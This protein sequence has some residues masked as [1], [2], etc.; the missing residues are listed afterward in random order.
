PTGGV[1]RHAPSILK[2][3]CGIG[4]P[5][6]QGESAKVRKRRFSPIAPCPRECPLTE[7]V[8]V[9]QAWPRERGLPHSGPYRPAREPADGRISDRRVDRASGRR[10][11]SN[12]GKIGTSLGRVAAPRDIEGRDRPAEAL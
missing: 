8:A 1:S 5:R 9:A 3:C 2:V 7:P 12:D 4:P 11:A 10:A 6:S